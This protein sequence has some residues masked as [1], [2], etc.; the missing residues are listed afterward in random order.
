[1]FSI[2]CPNPYRILL[3]ASAF[4]VITDGPGWENWDKGNLFVEINDLQYPYEAVHQ[5]LYFKITFISKSF[6][7]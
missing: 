2:S 4:T 3:L 5:L 6:F 7:F 1:M